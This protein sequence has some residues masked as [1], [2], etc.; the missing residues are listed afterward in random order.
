MIEYKEKNIS[1]CKFLH[2]LH[3]IKAK[4]S[5]RPK[6]RVQFQSYFMLF[7]NLFLKVI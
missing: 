7:L 4:K 5:S 2:K 1:N 6:D 3:Q